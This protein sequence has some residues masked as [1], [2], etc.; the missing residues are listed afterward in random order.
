MKLKTQDHN[1]KNRRWNK[2][3]QQLEIL[4]KIREKGKVNGFDVDLAEAQAKDYIRMDKKVGAIE[5]DVRLMK[6][7]IRVLLENQARQGG[8][9]DLIVK[10]MD[11]PVEEERKDAI[12][13]QQ[14]KGMLSTTMGKIFILL[15]FG[16]IG[17]AGQR[18]LELI[19]LIK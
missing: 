11:S 12:F 4:E 15:A 19:G 16:C 18:I 3:C 1:Q 13:W 9:I 8:Q 6:K 14:I 7:D 2:M 10:R 5:K 17:L